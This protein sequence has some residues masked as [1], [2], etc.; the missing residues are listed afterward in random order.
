MAFAP[1]IKSDAST[2]R[3]SFTAEV[4]PLLPAKN[5]SP[6]I[7]RFA[8]ALAEKVRVWKTSEEAKAGG[9]LKLDFASI[10]GAAIPGLEK[11]QQENSYTPEDNITVKLLAEGG[12]N[13]IWLVTSP[14]KSNDVPSLCV[15]RMPTAESLKPWQVRN[16]VGWLRYMT[17]NHSAM[18]VPQVYA[19][20]DGATEGEL[21][22]VV[23]QFIEGLP[24]SEAWKSYSES[25][26]EEVARKVAK[27]VVQLGE[28]RFDAIGGMQPD[29]TL[30]PTVEG[31]KLF[32][33][34]DAF[35][36]PA[37]Y[38][39]GPYGSIDQYILA[40]YDKEDYYYS[41][42]PD[43]D[44]DDDIFESHSRTDFIQ[45]L[46]VKRATVKAE[47]EASPRQESFVLCHSDLQGR[48][49]MMEGTEI[50]AIIDW[51]FAGSYPLS[52]LVDSGLEVLEI[53]DE[54]STEEC[55]TWCDKIRTLTEQ[56]ARE[57]HW[58][59]SDVD[60]LMSEGD[61][62]LQGARV[63]MLPEYSSETE[64]NDAV[65]EEPSKR[66]ARLSW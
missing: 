24:L 49:F 59:E 58:K 23:E 25:E 66:S 42:A 46:R 33:G 44:L 22:F 51:E 3:K 4:A 9:V 40:Y 17:K 61:P 56:I 13:E 43:S 39:V 37:Y 55:F 48:N 41:Y 2:T 62:V 7:A 35:H 28:I 20:S 1:N 26:K 29:G 34:R 52:E 21:P 12:Y 11:A 50:A 8:P 10:S 6:T 47:L 64:G 27:V 18:P 30:G 53:E 63:E 38:D 5:A 15:L 32:R 65:G 19:Y 45:H 31:V 36:D 14:V 60:L 57:R 54:E 16:E